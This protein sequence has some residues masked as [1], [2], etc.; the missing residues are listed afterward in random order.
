VNISPRRQLTQALARGRA[1][2]MN[3]STV[4]GGAVLWG[5]TIAFGAS[6]LV[7]LAILDRH[8]YSG[9]LSGAAAI[10]VLTYVTAVVPGG[11][12]LRA[13]SHASDGEL[14]PPVGWRNIALLT[15]GLAVVSPLVAF[16][17]HIPTLAIL[18]ILAQMFIEV[19]VGARRGTLLGTRA[20]GGLGASLFIEA[21]GRVILGTLLG[22]RFGLEGL[23]LGILLASFFTLGLTSLLRPGHGQEPPAEARM[24]TTLAHTTITIGFMALLAQLDVILVPSALGGSAADHYDVAAVPAKAIFLGLQVGGWLLFPFARRLTGKAVAIVP[25]LVT[26]GVGALGTGV[27]IALRPF[28]AFVLDQGT[29]SGLLLGVL[30][31]AMALAGGTGVCITASVARG[32]HRPWPPLLAGCAL[33]ACAVPL[34]HGP[35]SFALAILT[36]QAMALVLSI[37]QVART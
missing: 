27:L 12:Q 9:G 29:P 30:G 5:G 33:S 35:L 20:F 21:G 3:K 17:A 32:T 28:I 6:T 14:R 1:S 25:A 8:L 31:L 15:L 4:L 24:V 22:I 16:V 10:L 36:V 19:A 11:V 13:A 34:F 37:A 7:I 18:A 23:A 2:G 26:V